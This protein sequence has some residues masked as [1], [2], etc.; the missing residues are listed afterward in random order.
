MVNSSMRNGH[1]FAA[2][3]S[4]AVLAAVA[5]GG[6][7]PDHEGVLGTASQNDTF[8][9]G[10][11]DTSRIAAV[12]NFIGSLPVGQ[13]GVNYEVSVANFADPSVPSGAVGGSTRPPNVQGAYNKLQNNY[14]GVLP[15]ESGTSGGGGASGSGGGSGATGGG[16]GR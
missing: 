6:Q 8:V 16:G 9:T 11:I 10:T 1:R 13:R 7:Q 4:V 2:L 12:Q 15:G 14:Q 5:C 3:W